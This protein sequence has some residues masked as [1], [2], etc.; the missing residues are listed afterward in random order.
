MTQR[1][2]FTEEGLR[3]PSRQGLQQLPLQLYDL[4]LNHGVD[5]ASTV[6]LN[7]AAHLQEQSQGHYNVD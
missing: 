7:L 6:T 1:S 5:D 3:V 2:R 4:P